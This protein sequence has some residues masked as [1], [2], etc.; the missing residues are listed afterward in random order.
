MRYDDCL[1]GLL[2]EAPGCPDAVAVRALRFT[3]VDWCR[4]TYHFTTG[5]T[6]TTADPLVAPA[7]PA[8]PMVTFDIV[9]ARVADKPIAVLPMNSLEVDDATVED[10]VLI[11]AE[12]STLY[13]MPTPA[14]PVS[15]DIIAAQ[16]PSHDG[17]EF[18]DL[19]WSSN[20]EAIEHGAIARLLTMVGKPWSSPEGASFHGAL[21]LADLTRYAGLYGR[22]RLS[23]ARRLRVKPA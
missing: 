13:M 17:E 15:V 19:L 4:R 5:L 3:V 1:S 7:L 10:P 12:P 22:N 16:C 6:V 8:G 9:D 20:H 18:P 14:A 23:N 11:F 21:Y 2:L